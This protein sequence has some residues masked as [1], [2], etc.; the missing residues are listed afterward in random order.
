MKDSFQE[1]ALAALGEVSEGMVFA[2]HEHLRRWAFR[3]HSNYCI[4]VAR[5]RKP[6]SIYEYDSEFPSD[7]ID[8]LTRGEDI[9]ALTEAIENLPDIYRRAIEGVL[10]GRS[11]R[12]IAAD[13]VG[14]RVN[15]TTNVRIHRA[16]KMLR[17]KLEGVV[18]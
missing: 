14:G 15:S 17:G 7:F 1:V 9:R 4:D 5:K 10:L 12:E 6:V 18:A 2:S 13:S 3:V 16:K 8:E 11:Y